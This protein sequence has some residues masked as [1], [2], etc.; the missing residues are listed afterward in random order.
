MRAYTNTHFR[1]NTECVF[2]NLWLSDS[3]EI[4]R[5]KWTHIRTHV[6]TLNSGH[7]YCCV[8]I[9]DIYRTSSASPPVRFCGRILKIVSK[10]H[11]KVLI[12]LF[13]PSYSSIFLPFTASFWL[14]LNQA[15]R[16][17]T[18][19][20]PWS[21]SAVY[22][23]V[24]PEKMELSCTGAWL[25]SKVILNLVVLAGEEGTHTRASGRVNVDWRIFGTPEQEKNPQ[26]Q[27]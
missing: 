15:T 2:R 3:T 21:V 1:I 25:V 19:R 26:R 27:Q 22:W 10:A 16:A 17:L 12:C 18:D 13:L 8:I 4:P 6:L 5:A 7:L 20:S 23:W 24:L 14:V 11:I 9:H